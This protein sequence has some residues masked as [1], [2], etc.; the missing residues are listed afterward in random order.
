MRM[1]AISV[2][3]QPVPRAPKAPWVVV[4]LSVATTIMPGYTTPASAI[5]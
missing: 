4:W 3:P 1:Q 5:T 2:A